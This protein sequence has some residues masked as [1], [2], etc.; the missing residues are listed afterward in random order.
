MTT[1]ELVSKLRFYRHKYVRWSEMN[2]KVDY[3]NGY[4]GLVLTGYVAS[5]HPHVVFA[6]YDPQPAQVLSIAHT[7]EALQMY[8]DK[9]F[10]VY[11]E[12]AKDDLREVT[13]VAIDTPQRLALLQ[14]A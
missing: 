9:S 14:I 11:V 3:D 4:H 13:D 1:H 12:V 8:E 5:P 2:L 10:S 7:I 6:L